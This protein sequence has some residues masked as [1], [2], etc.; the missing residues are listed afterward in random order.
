[1]TFL[2]SECPAYDPKPSDCEAASSGALGNVEYLFITITS[3]L[4]RND[5]TRYSPI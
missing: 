1:M 3:N 5:S 2:L 4:T